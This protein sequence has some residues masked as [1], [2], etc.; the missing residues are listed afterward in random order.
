MAEILII[1][2]GVSGLSAGIYA[3]LNG[4]HATI[5]ERQ[6]I[7]GGNLTG[8]QRGEYHIDNCIHWLTGTNP[9]SA[10]YA[11]WEDLGAL[12]KVKVYQADALYTYEDEGVQVSLYRD[13]AE[14]EDELLK[15]APEDEREIKRFI[16]AIKTV[17]GHNGIL[18]ANNDKKSNVFQ[19]L[20]ALPSMY[21]YFKMTTGELAKRF[22]NPQLQGFITSMLGKDFASLALIITFA[23]FCGGNGGIPKGSSLA[24][25][26]RITEKF[27]RL[28]GTLY[29]KRE[30]VKITE[31]SDGKQR[32]EFSDGTS[33]EA[34]YVI[35]TVEP[36]VAFEKLLNLPLPRALAKRYADPKM[37]R[38]SSLQ[39]AFGCDCAKLPFRGDFIF[40]LPKAEQK[41]LH[42][43]NLIIREFSHEKEFSPKGHNLIQSLIFCGEKTCLQFIKLRNKPVEYQQ[44]KQEIAQSVQKCIEKKFPQ[45]QG[46][47]RC[48]DVWTPATYH[49]Y[50]NAEV[51]SYMSFLLPPK[52]IPKKLDNRV[53]QRPKVFLATQWLQS[54]GGLPIAAKMGK[55]AVDRIVKKERA[56]RNRKIQVTQL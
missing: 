29:L 9:N 52:I 23:T 25:A 51:G 5:C 16:K 31:S 47:L 45:L 4:H 22:K 3:Q 2:A 12:G 55:D 17:Q 21:R 40:K 35:L 6:A 44:K 15:V 36:S 56:K 46:K 24:M 8:W 49:R 39:C 33:L 18:G 14:L 37:P 32:V 38:F 10:S 53:K 30:A 11:L 34:D 54:P 27:L 20:L 26:K 1:G 48:I 28:G 7:A 50:T 43:E 13:L 19:E 42:A 41:K